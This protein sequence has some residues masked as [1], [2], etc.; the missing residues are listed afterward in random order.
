[1]LAAGVSH[2]QVRDA[3][4]VCAAFNTTNRLAD[5]FG[6]EQLSPAGFEAGAA[7]LIKRGYR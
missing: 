7:Y 2:Q 4:A 1:M 6:F 5:A 3:L